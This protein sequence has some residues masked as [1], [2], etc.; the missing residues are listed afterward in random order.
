MGKTYEAERGGHCR[1]LERG[2]V[3]IRYENIV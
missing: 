1:L 2:V 3:P